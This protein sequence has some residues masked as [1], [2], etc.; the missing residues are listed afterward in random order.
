MIPVALPFPDIDPVAIAIGPLT[1]KWYGLAY[2]VGPGARLAL[3]QTC[4]RGPPALG[5]RQTAVP[6]RESRRSPPLPHDRHRH[7]WRLGYVILYE[8]S[9]YLAQPIDIFAVWK[10]GMSFH[11]ALIGCGFATWVFARRNA[12]QSVDGARSRDAAVLSGCSSAGSRTS[13]MASYSA[14]SPTCRGRWYFRM[15]S[16]S[17]RRSSRRRGTRASSTK[18]RSRASCCSSLCGPSLTRTRRS[19]GQ[20][21]RGRV[22]TG[23]AL[24]RMT[25]EIFRE[26]HAVHASRYSDR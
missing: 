3:Y 23:Y 14:A 17:I 13:S 20:R 11:G 15:Q 18:Q 2:L 5:R 22:A 8:P 26:P 4:R 16:T 6:A 24:A 21:R 7:W 9:A 1:I 12:H 19:S 10:G 25:G